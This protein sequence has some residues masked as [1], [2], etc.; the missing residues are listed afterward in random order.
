EPEARDSDK[1]ATP[2]RQSD[3]PTKAS[4]S[5]APEGDSAGENEPDVD[6]PAQADSS[7]G[8]P[9]DDAPKSHP[10]GRSEAASTGEKKRRRRR[11]GK[12]TH[13]DGAAA[14]PEANAAEGAPE[15]ADEASATPV[16]EGEAIAEDESRPKSGKKQAR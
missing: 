8:P 3:V 1:S 16:E 14:K 2:D 13:A 11:R 7:A 4:A 6:A 15:V 5:P 9:M 12:K 10:S